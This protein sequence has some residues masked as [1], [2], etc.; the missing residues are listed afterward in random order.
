VV[1]KS[2]S[3]LHIGITPQ[4]FYTVRNSFLG[5]SFGTRIS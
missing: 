5:L 4:T 2:G 1:N 3:C